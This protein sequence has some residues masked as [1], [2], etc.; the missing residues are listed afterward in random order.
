MYTRVESNGTT[1]HVLVYGRGLYCVLGSPTSPL[2]LRSR[3]ANVP[4]VSVEL[5]ANLEKTGHSP[6]ENTNAPC[7]RF[8]S[9]KMDK[10]IWVTLP[11][12]ILEGVP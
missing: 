12:S 9:G 1:S 3:T 7:C 2:A 6:G 4:A 10:K 11:G 5:A 8:F